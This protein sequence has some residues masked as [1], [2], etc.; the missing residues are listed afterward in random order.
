MAGKSHVNALFFQ[1]SDI[2]RQRYSTLCLNVPIVY[3]LGKGGGR[4]EKGEERRDEGRK[5]RREEGAFPGSGLS[6]EEV[7]CM[8]SVNRMTQ[9]PMD[10]DYVY[11]F[12]YSATYATTEDR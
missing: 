5:G 3:L 1:R 12:I 7:I 2:F 10:W 4:E 9:W 6:W 8:V 11:S